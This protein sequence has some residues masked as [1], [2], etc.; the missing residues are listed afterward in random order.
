MAAQKCPDSFS[1]Y[2]QVANKMICYGALAKQE[3][4]R[5]KK[6]ATMK[7][8]FA[9]EMASSQQMVKSQDMSQE[10]EELTSLIRKK[11]TVYICWWLES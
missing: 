10:L 4:W 8:E 2:F 5:A 6:E 11:D 9:W 3:E 7:W 1:S